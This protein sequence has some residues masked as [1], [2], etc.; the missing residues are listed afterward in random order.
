MNFEEYLVSKKIDSAAFK[1]S[2]PARWEE[3]KALL[4]KI[5][6]VSF[7]QQKLYLINPIRRKYPLKIQPVAPVE[8][9]KDAPA[10]PT[11]PKPFKPVFKPKI[12]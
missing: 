5:S 2:E 8:E 1:Q 6:P 7:T 9:K 4:E 12:N 10:P 3:W 11:A